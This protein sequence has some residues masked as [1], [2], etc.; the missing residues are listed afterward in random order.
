MKYLIQLVWLAVCVGIC[1]LIAFLLP[2][3]FAQG[4]FT[5][6]I[7][8]AGV[9]F[10]WFYGNKLL[11]EWYLRWTGKAAKSSLDKNKL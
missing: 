4:E 9:S 3:L 11:L 6:T 7:I 2:G 8:C 1:V 10:V 5:G